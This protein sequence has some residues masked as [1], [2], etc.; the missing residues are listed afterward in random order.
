MSD[1]PPSGNQMFRSLVERSIAVWDTI[2]YVSLQIPKDEA[3]SKHAETLRKLDSVEAFL[4]N[5]INQCW[6]FQ[7][8][9]AF[10]KQSLFTKWDPNRLDDYVLLPVDYGFAN[11]M[12]CFFISH[13]WRT[14][15]HPDPD[16]ED[17]TLNRQDLVDLEWSYVWVDWTCLPQGPRNKLEQ[18]YF[19]RMLRNIPMLVRDCA[20]SWRF[21]RFEPRAWVLFEVAEYI[22]NHRQFVN[23]DDIHTFVDHIGEMG[24]TGVKEVVK[25]YGYKCTNESD[26][27]LVVGWLEI[28]LILC[29]VVPDV[30][31]R[32][33]VFD[34]LNRPFVG[35][36]QLIHWGLEIDKSKGI[37]KCNGE[38]YEFTPVYT[39]DY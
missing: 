31:D 33:M 26:A 11:N 24:H 37:I 19:K 36:L 38:T 6:F 12:D 14:P 20:F 27:K 29:K 39:T 4:E 22:L 30:G 16:G 7:T 15:D 5:H 21:P 1:V 3:I 2:N 34:E 35:S 32:Q 10:M 13:Y 28:L 18:R 17:L 8:R 25:K 23:T 9:E